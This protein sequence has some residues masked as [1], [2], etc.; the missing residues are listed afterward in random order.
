MFSSMKNVYPSSTGQAKKITNSLLFMGLESNVVIA[1]N[2][3]SY[4]AQHGLFIYLLM[5]RFKLK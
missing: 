4:G 1:V 5:V 3:N 2:M